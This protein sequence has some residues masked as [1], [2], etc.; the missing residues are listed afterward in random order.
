[1][2]SAQQAKEYLGRIGCAESQAPTLPN[3]QSLMTCHLRAVPYET[4]TIHRSGRTPCLSTDA[5]FEKIVANRGGGYCFEQNKLF[6]ELLCALGYDAWPCMARSTDTPGRIDPI[7]H[8]AVV[9][10]LEGRSYLADVGW[11]GPMAAGPLLLEPCGIQTVAGKDYEVTQESSHWLTID[12]FSSKASDDGLPLRVGVMELCL[13]EMMD[14]DFDALNRKFSAPGSEFHDTEI[15]NLSTP[16]GYLA[17]E[18]RK[19]TVME[20]GRKTTTELSAEEVD[21]V[22]RER[23]GLS[24]PMPSAGA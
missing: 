20:N 22:L 12:R 11:G 19:L 10:G 24:L 9:V 8:R 4:A 23:F 5:L 13:A 3:L 17:L 6:Q 18:G 7:N 1:M 2:L 16:S 15:V 14:E 21:R